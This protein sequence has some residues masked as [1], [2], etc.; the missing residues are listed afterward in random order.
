MYEYETILQGV[1]AGGVIHT[2][3]SANLY[4]ESMTNGFH[5][6][7]LISPAHIGIELIQKFTA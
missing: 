4:S 2:E 3:A 6:L 1:G 7:L 5:S